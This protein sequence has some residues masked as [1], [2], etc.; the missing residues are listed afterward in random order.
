M[1]IRHLIR[2]GKEQSKK[3]KAAGS[4]DSSSDS[5]ESS[6]DEPATFGR[7]ASAGTKKHKARMAKTMKGKR[8]AKTDKV[9]QQVYRAP[10]G[11]AYGD[12]DSD[13]DMDTPTAHTGEAMWT[14]DSGATGNFVTRDCPVTNVRK[15]KPTAVE[16]AAGESTA[17]DERADFV[18]WIEADDGS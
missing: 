1:Q 15:Y 4:S 13:E 10:A 14:V 12:S 7:A 17:A 9:K 18:G 8:N 16:V 2:K 3:R 5:D 11:T 6:D